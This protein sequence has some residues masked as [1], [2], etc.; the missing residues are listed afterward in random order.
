[1]AELLEP[2]SRTQQWMTKVAESTDPHWK[3]VSSFLHK[4]A[5]RGKDKKLKASQ[6]KL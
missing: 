1:M 2:F 5:Q 4:I 3:T 6:A